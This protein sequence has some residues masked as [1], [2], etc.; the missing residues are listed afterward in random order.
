MLTQVSDTGSAATSTI[1]PWLEQGHSYSFKVAAKS[2]FRVGAASVPSE[3]MMV[4][5]A[6]QLQGETITGDGDDE[7]AEL[8]SD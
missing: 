4:H 6:R 5:D 8:S 3:T 7:S 2:E 1:I